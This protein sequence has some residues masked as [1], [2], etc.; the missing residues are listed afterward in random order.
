MIRQSIYLL[1]I[2]FSFQIFESC[3]KKDTISE[4]KSEIQNRN[5]VFLILI[6]VD[7]KVSNR[8]T[9]FNYKR[10]SKYSHIGILITKKRKSII[11]DVHPKKIKITNKIC[12][13]TID[14][15]ISFSKKPINYIGIWK[16]NFNNVE[17]ICQNI[18]L[19]EKVVYDYQFDNKTN[20]SLYCSEFVAK[21]LDKFTKHNSNWIFLKKTLN[22]TERLILKKNVINYYPVDFFMNDKSIIFISEW[23]FEKK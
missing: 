14:E 21:T 5:G 12:S 2:C 6:G 1:V 16:L 18:N 23:T 8:I 9:S 19:N 11:Y 22:K 3:N 15:F 4:F 10:K 20:S 13:Q 17:K 7:D